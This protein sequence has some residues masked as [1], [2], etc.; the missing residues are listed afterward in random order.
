[1][2]QYLLEHPLVQFYLLVVGALTIAII[3]DRLYQSWHP[4]DAPRSG[5]DHSRARRDGAEDARSVE[6]RQYPR[7][8]HPLPGDSWKNQ[9]G[10]CQDRHSDRIKE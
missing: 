9:P 3:H 8:C 6:Y 7:Y 1:V 2:G 10:R 4:E 5:E